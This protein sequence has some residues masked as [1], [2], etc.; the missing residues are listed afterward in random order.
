ML[1]Y[2]RHLFLKKKIN[3]SS[4]NLKDDIHLEAV[5]FLVE[6][7]NVRIPEYLADRVA[8]E[9]SVYKNCHLVRFSSHGGDGACFVLTQICHLGQS[10]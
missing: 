4:L 3:I 2:N 10:G 5:Y 6:S 9:T 7:D 8:D 1:L